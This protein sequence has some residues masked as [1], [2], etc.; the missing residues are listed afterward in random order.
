MILSLTVLEGL[1]AGVIEV[2]S[3]EI[4]DPAVITEADAPVYRIHLRHLGHR[5]AIVQDG[6]TPNRR[7]STSAS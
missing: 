4:V 3:V 1:E 2:V 7:R 6:R 5:Q